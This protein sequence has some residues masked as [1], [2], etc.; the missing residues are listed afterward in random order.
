[1]VEILPPVT[2]ELLPLST[3]VRRK[4][5]AYQ[6]STRQGVIT[7][8]GPY[9]KYIPFEASET[10]SWAYVSKLRMSD[11]GADARRR[12]LPS[13][14]GNYNEGERCSVALVPL[15]DVQLNDLRMHLALYEQYENA[16]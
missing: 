3:E 16:T 11:I 5:E 14:N 2:V 13:T 7:G 1:M 10:L 8:I 9:Q 12:T 15:N 4:V 6:N